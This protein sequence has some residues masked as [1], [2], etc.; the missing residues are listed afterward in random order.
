MVPSIWYMVIRKLFHL[1]SAS[2]MNAVMLHRNMINTPLSC[3]SQG[4]FTG[5]WTSWIWYMICTP[6][7][8][9]PGLDQYCNIIGMCLESYKAT[10]V[11]SI[12]KKRLLSKPLMPGYLDYSMHYSWRCITRGSQYVR[13][14]YTT[15]SSYRLSQEDR[16]DPTDNF[17]FG[18]PVTTQTESFWTD[19]SWDSFS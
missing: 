4:Y 15:V 16:A 13:S 8:S 3:Q 17:Y 7:Q 11:H 18:L 6:D 5:A 9:L 2:K 10:R 12:I 19:W 1:S 14:I